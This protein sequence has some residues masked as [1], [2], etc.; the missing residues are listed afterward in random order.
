MNLQVL[1]ELTDKA[2][3]IEQAKEEI[4]AIKLEDYAI[5][6]ELQIRSSSGYCPIDLAAIPF[7]VL[8]KHLLA[9]VREAKEKIE[10]DLKEAVYE[11]KNEVQG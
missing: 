11:V 4:E 6:C 10:K 7:E 5:Y 9:A 1:K 2:Y 3:D 8:R